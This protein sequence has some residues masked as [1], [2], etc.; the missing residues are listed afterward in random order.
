[1]KIQRQKIITLMCELHFILKLA[2]K[3]EHK[4]VHRI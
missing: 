2:L 3:Y 1:M 4:H